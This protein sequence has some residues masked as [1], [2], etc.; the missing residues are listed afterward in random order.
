MFFDAFP[1]F[2][3]TSETSPF[4]GRLHLRYEAIF[5]A[6][7]DVFAGARVLDIASHDGRWSLAALKTGAAEVIG[8]EA[9]EE[10]VRAA[11]ENL[12]LYA[13]D[14]GRH[15]FIEGDVFDVLARQNLAVDVVLCLGFLYHTLRYNELMSR[16]RGI[17]PSY[18]IIDTKVLPRAR[19]P[20]VQLRLNDTARQR[21]AVADA[22]SYDNKALV[23]KPSLP[24]L[25]L[26]VETFGF[27]I[28]RFSDWGSLIRDNPGVSR[29]GDY[30]TGQRVTARCF[31]KV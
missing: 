2:Y 11:R 6:N 9:R 17:G 3:E 12:A 23:G 15:T 18:L 25:K 5:A 31:S 4:R 29:V 22:Y 10:L 19:K 13:G 28:E 20:I 26:I 8:I 14:D 7:R 16:I 30:A 1:R 24:A 21:A 27:E